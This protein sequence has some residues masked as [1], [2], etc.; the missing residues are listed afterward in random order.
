MILTEGN[1]SKYFSLHAAFHCISDKM[2]VKNLIKMGM[3]ACKFKYVYPSSCSTIIHWVTT[4]ILNMKNFLLRVSKELTK[5]ITLEK[6]IHKEKEELKFWIFRLYGL[7]T[8][9]H[10]SFYL[11]VFLE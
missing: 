7:R 5:E 1:Y 9:M 11:K 8:R 4:L 10:K 3:N 2:N 6:P